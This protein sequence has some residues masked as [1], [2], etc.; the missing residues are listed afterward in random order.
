MGR[1][2]RETT[3]AGL[4]TETER[5]GE[6]SQAGG[7]NSCTTERER[8]R[9]QQASGQPGVWSITGLTLIIIQL[10]WERYLMLVSFSQAVT[11]GGKSLTVGV[12][13]WGWPHCRETDSRT[14]AVQSEN[15]PPKLIHFPDSLSHTLPFKRLGLIRF[16]HQG[17]IYLIKNNN[18]MKSV[19][20][21]KISV[22][23]F[24]KKN[25]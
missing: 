7:G 11:G 18:I 2:E 10:T 24:Y 20:L 9:G 25:I 6:N 17:S 14:R 1:G 3:A 13:S 22:F 15:H 23:Y 21:F 8:S 16:V 5:L 4:D 19:L 12:Q